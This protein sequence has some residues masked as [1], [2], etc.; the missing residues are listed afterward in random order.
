MIMSFILMTLMCDS[1]VILWG[2]IRCKLQLAVKGLKWAK[3]VVTASRRCLRYLLIGQGSNQNDNFSGKTKQKV[4]SEGGFSEDPGPGARG[5]GP[6]P[7]LPLQICEC[8]YDFSE[9]KNSSNN[10]IAQCNST[11]SIKIFLILIHIVISNVYF[12]FN[13]K[14]SVFSES[15]LRP[16]CQKGVTPWFL[17]PTLV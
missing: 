13:V 15:K 10:R 4:F 8:S 11:W 1:V 6:P 5:P 17:D 3:P 7:T 14:K 16:P 9:T 12:G 2:E